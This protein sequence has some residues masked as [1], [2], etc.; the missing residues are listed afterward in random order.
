MIL[1]KTVIHYGYLQKTEINLVKKFAMEYNLKFLHEGIRKLSIRNPKWPNRSFRNFVRNAKYSNFIVIWNGMQ[2]YGPLITR[3]CKEKNIPR[4]YMEWGMMRQKDNFF[5]DPNG[6]CGD[7]I[8]SK[9]L[10]W[11]NNNDIDI[12]HQKR[13]ILQN[14]YHIED[15][16][17]ILVPLQIENDSQVLFYSKYKNMEELLIDIINLY[18]NQYKIIIK[19]HPKEECKIYKQQQSKNLQELF[20]KYNNIFFADK[21]DNFLELAS[22]ASMVVGISSTTLYE[23]GVL[24][25]PIIS[26]GIHPLNTDKNTQEK[27]IAGACF[28]NID[29]NT[30]SLKTVLDRFDIKPL[31]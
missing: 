30:G 22:K 18:G 20:I 6:F 21:A 19:P 10:S 25:K 17:Y 9:D 26:L 1:N 8:L 27:V 11:I 24:G 2:C 28:L 15:R 12:M 16:D 4:C 7:S 14:I 23:A 3:L 29:R 13:K 5:I 31:T